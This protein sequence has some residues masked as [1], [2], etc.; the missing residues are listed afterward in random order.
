MSDPIQRGYASIRIREQPQEVLL[1]DL[2][3][4]ISFYEPRRPTLNKSRRQLEWTKKQRD[5]YEADK[6]VCERKRLELLS[7]FESLAVIDFPGEGACHIQRVPGLIE[8]LTSRW[9]PVQ[10]ARH[11]IKTKLK[12]DKQFT[13]VSNLDQF[14]WGALCKCFRLQLDGGEYEEDDLI[15]EPPLKKQRIE[16]SSTGPMIESI[17]FTEEDFN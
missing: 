8:P 1:C 6:K 16:T 14:D 11:W 17:V 13:L 15:V 5:D 2:V 10:Q 3:L 7:R 9:I 12:Q 4:S